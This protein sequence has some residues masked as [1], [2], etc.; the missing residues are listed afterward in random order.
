[1]VAALADVIAA[2]VVFAGGDDRRL[3]RSF[4]GMT[5]CMLLWNLLLGS[6]SIPGFS[7]AHR[8]TIHFLGFGLMMLPA[9][10]FHNACIFSGARRRWVPGLVA[11]GYVV[12]ALLCGLQATDW[13]LDGFVEQPW[14]SVGR[15]APLY[16][17]FAAFMLL[18]VSLGIVLCARALNTTAN[19][20]VKLRTKYWLLAAAGAFP[21]GITNILANYGVPIIPLGSLGS[22]YIVALV[23]YASVRHRLMDIDFFVMRTA[24][25]LLASVV[26]VLPVA[27]A[28]I[29]VRDLPFGVSGFL[30][31]GCLLLAAL[32]SLG[33]FVRF[34]SYLEREVE[35]SLFPARQAAREAIHQLA[36]ELVLLSRR[37]DLGRRV[38]ATLTSGL[39]LK[40]A[41]LYVPAS[42]AQTFMRAGVEGAIQTPELLQ[43]DQSD[44]AGDGLNGFARRWQWA[45]CIP[46]PGNGS[47]LGFIALGPKRSGAAID[48]SDVTLV[49]VVAAQL[50]V[51]LK[52]AD[53][54]RKIERQAAEIA[55]L[56]RRLQAENVSLRAEVR[57]ITQFT[58]IVG[59]SPALQRLLVLIERT[60]STKASVL[61]TGETG[62][63]KELV[64]HAIHEVSPRRGRPFV[65]VNCAAIPP[66][67]A[68]SELFG[69]ERGAFTDAVS[70]RPGKFELAD[71]GTIFLDEVAELSPELQGKLLRVLQE[72][73]TQRVGADRVRKLDLRVVAASNRDL[74]VEMRAGRFRSDLYYRLA[75]VPVH[76]PALRERADDVPMLATFFLARAATMCQKPIRG[77]SADAMAA[78]CRYSWPGN[79]RELQHVVARAAL[80]CSTDVITSEQLSDLEPVEPGQPLSKHLRE[81]KLRQVQQAL[82]QTGGNQAAAARLLGMSRSNF[83]R[84][85]KSL[86]LKPP[87]AVQ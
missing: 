34:R 33:L 31:T 12:G 40:G 82:A 57:A 41:A 78:L 9:A 7:M 67:L 3:A 21:T 56:H 27:S 76:V 8:T 62:T 20:V 14:G 71:G 2:A 45:T 5:G 70:A 11:I 65:S 10:V 77:F 66:G 25:T 60:A 17:I 46:I 22:V 81:E 53:Y 83:A 42:A 73:E 16:G 64:A 39:A 49:T 19:P 79:V 51:A 55:E 43:A 6:E 48:D 26:V 85:L 13:I 28:A 37:D 54:V 72:H 15:P 68:E 47:C 32:V 30:V 44:S 86:G 61:I 63:G 24:A 1:L 69:H 74:R 80:L 50:A 4:V 52:N 84:L 75:A 23:T 59:S 58:D 87:S 38:S 29:W 36:S 35:R 18:W